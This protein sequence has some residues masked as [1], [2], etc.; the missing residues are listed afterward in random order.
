MKLIQH[1]TESR[2][3]ETPWQ[4]VTNRSI[5]QLRVLFKSLKPRVFAAVAVLF[6]FY[7]LSFFLALKAQ[8]N[9]DAQLPLDK[10]CII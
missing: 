1:R 7:L 5:I 4:H 10:S 3:C 9:S 6:C 8:F 2:A